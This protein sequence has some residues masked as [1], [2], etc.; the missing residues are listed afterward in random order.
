MEQL[1]S[2]ATK[3][4]FGDCWIQRDKNGLWYAYVSDK[5]MIKAS[6]G[7]ALTAYEA[8]QES[9]KRAAQHLCWECNEC[10]SQEYTMSVSSTDI[11]DL[12]CGSCGGSEFHKALV[13]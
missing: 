6:Y 13:K 5:M 9:T 4:Y 8:L 2:K 11:K 1:L 7:S 3:I 10:G 12:S